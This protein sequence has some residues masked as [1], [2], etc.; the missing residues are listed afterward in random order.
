[1]VFAMPFKD[2]LLVGTTDNPDNQVTVEPVLLKKE[3]DYL[4][5]TIQPYLSVK[6]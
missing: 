4:I 1:M 3:M 5:E 2:K 6:F